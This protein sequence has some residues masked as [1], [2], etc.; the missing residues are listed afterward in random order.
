MGTQIDTAQ[1]PPLLWIF[2]LGF[3]AFAVTLICVWLAVLDD[4]AFWR[5]SAKDNGP[6]IRERH[7]RHVP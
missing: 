3:Y 7:C 2:L 4:T 5:Q 1:R 6:L